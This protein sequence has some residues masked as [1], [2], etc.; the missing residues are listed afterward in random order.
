MKPDDYAG[1]AAD[2]SLASDIAGGTALGAIAGIAAVAIACAPAIA[3]PVIA[4]LAVVAVVAAVAS[5][6]AGAV[7]DNAAQGVADSAHVA[8]ASVE[9]PDTPTD[10]LDMKFF[11]Q[12]K[13]ALQGTGAHINIVK[14]A[15][16]EWAPAADF[17]WEKLL[18]VIPDMHLMNGDVASVWR[19]KP[20]DLQPELDF[21]DF[22][23]CLTRLDLKDNIH[24]AQIG[25]SYDLWVGCAPRLYR[26]NDDWAMELKPRL[27][28]G[29]D[30][31][32]AR[33][34]VPDPAQ[35]VKNWIKDIQGLRGNWVQ[36]IMDQ[37]AKDGLDDA[38]ASARYRG[39]LKQ[40][41][42][43]D[44]PTA[45]MCGADGC[46]THSRPEDRCV[47]HTCNCLDPAC[48]GHTA[49]GELCENGAR[50][51][52][53]AIGCPGHEAA[54]DLCRDALWKCGRVVWTDDSTWHP[55]CEGHGSANEVCERQGWLNPAEAGFRLLERE[56]FGRM[57]YIYGNHDNYLIIPDVSADI[58]PRVRYVDDVRSVFVEHGHR[59]EGTFFEGGVYP[60]PVN[61]DGQV[62]GYETTIG[63][64]NE[65]RH[66][67]PHNPIG[68]LW[69]NLKQKAGK[70]VA[71]EWAG[72]HDQ[73]QYRGEMAQIWLGRQ[74]AGEIKPFHIYVIGHTH[75]P[76]LWYVPI[77]A[78]RT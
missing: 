68:Q 58:L 20:H 52:C 6:A 19:Q 24:L 59:M 69:A 39:L 1:K 72:I 63:L 4:V 9:V 11:Q 54:S 65:Y 21:L 51:T 29:S 17:D 73:P 12:M 60:L 28:P 18:I 27:D 3:I 76:N 50:Y 7:A 38:N 33:D 42:A 49:A 46:Q 77:E 26:K 30:D 75:M 53:G 25:D 55:D 16:A 31:A 32:E 71:D 44:A 41:S 70:P 36:R 22:A 66:T 5:L 43:D 62:S 56:L 15:S 78:W 47:P 8:D 45:W 74:A 57:S 64:Y 2:Y 35:T 40:D 23:D 13:S 37:R 61:F 67:V 48:P 34:S 10:R 14:R